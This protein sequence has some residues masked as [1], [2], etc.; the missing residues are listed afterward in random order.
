MIRLAAIILALCI[1]SAALAQQVPPYTYPLTL[2]TSS[3]TVLPADPARKKVIF[4]NPNDQAKIAVCPIGPGRAVGSSQSLIIAAINGAG[5][6]QFFRTRALK[7]AAAP[8]AAR[9]SRWVRHESASPARQGQTRQSGNSSDAP[10][11]ICVSI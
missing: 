5:S 7:S 10:S 11:A 6:S 1:T 9:S 3:V 8:R 4:H 2:G